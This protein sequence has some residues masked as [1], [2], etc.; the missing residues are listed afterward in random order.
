MKTGGSEANAIR[1]LEMASEPP[2]LECSMI[3]VVV[4][5]RPVG[6]G[7]VFYHESASPLRI[8]MLVAACV[9]IGVAARH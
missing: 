8:V 3:E 1:T 2:F 7:A 5:N 4:R 6:K 9:L